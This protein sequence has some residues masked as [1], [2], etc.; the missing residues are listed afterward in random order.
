M[1]EH[2]QILDGLRPEDTRFSFDPVNRN[3]CFGGGGGGLGGV[4]SGLTGALGM[5]GGQDQRMQT[6]TSTSIQASK[7]EKLKIPAGLVKRRT[8]SSIFRLSAVPQ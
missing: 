8:L 2:I 7:Q 6:S 1:K 3:L 5:G 4:V